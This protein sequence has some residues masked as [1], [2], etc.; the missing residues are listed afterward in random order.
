MIK[1]KLKFMVFVNGL[2]F[3]IP[4]KKSKMFLLKKKKHVYQHWYIGMKQN[5]RD[6]N[7][8]A[9]ICKHGEPTHALLIN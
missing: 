2:M 9:P 1:L 7:C 3:K 6:N 5:G 8:I 4:K